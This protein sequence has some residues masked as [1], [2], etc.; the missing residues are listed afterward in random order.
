MEEKDLI[1]IFFLMPQVFK[2]WF[3][4]N[5]I[6]AHLFFSYFPFLTFFFHVSLL[7]CHFVTD[8]KNVVGKGKGKERQRSVVSQKRRK[9]DICRSSYVKFCSKLL[10][11]TS[12]FS[13]SSAVCMQNVKKMDVLYIIS[14]LYIIR[15]LIYNI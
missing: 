1:C 3:I 8:G 13:A 4:I 12:K 14:M 15:Y 10:K 11:F 2:E 6:Q 7:F 9:G 5:F